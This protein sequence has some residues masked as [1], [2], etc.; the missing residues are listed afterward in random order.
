LNQGPYSHARNNHAPRQCQD[1][2]N[3]ARNSH[4]SSNHNGRRI[5]KVDGKYFLKPGRDAGF[6]VFWDDYFLS[7]CLK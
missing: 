1:R 2:S 7:I 3:R 6:F 4:T 5:R